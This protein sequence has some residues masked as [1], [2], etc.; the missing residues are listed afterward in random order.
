MQTFEPQ[1]T[2]LQ[3]QLLD[4]LDAPA[5]AYT[6]ASD[7]HTSRRTD[8]GPGAG[9][10]GRMDWDSG[11]LSGDILGDV[12]R[13]RSRGSPAARR[14][15]QKMHLA[16]G[17]R[18]GALYERL[19]IWREKVAVLLPVPAVAGAPSNAIE[20]AADGTDVLTQPVGPASDGHHG[21]RKALGDA[22]GHVRDHVTAI[23]TRTV[24]PT[25]LAGARPG[26]AAAAIAGCIAIGSGASYCVDQGMGPIA[27]FAGVD[28][29][30][31]VECEKERP[32]K[33]ARSRRPRRR[34]R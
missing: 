5:S 8:T 31:R 9:A 34:Q 10:N 18:C 28:M 17:P 33:K 12:S 21:F 15:A 1:L 13:A 27:R 16:T 7:P 25:P 11:R 6:T 23:D 4:L 14:N 2:P 24:D 3:A 19:D 32:R 22:V 30:A 29:P 20:R 26:A